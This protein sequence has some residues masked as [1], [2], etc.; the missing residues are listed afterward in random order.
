MTPRMTQR[1]MAQMGGRAL[2]A[3]MTPEQRRESARRAALARWVAYRAARDVR[4][5]AEP[6]R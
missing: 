5:T 2:A 4:R 3:K 6:T 1:R